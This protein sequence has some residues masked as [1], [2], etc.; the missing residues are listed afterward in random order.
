MEA[1]IYA[2]VVEAMS[3]HEFGRMRDPERIVAVATAAMAGGRQQVEALL[4][5]DELTAMVLAIMDAPL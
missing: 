4:L 3:N 5:D 1:D 2:K